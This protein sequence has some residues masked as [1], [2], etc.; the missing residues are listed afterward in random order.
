MTDTTSQVAMRPPRIEDGY[1]RP[2]VPERERFFG[3]ARSMAAPA[4][5]SARANLEASRGGVGPYFANMP[6]AALNLADAAVRGGVGAFAD[7]VPGLSPAAERDLAR[8]VLGMGEA[9]AGSVMRVPDALDEGLGGLSEVARRMF[10]EG[11]VPDTLYSGFDPQAYIRGLQGRAKESDAQRLREDLDA[12]DQLRAERG[13]PPLNPVPRPADPVPEDFGFYQDNPALKMSSG[14]EWLENKQRVADE[15]YGQRRGIT[16]STTATLGSG[17][18]DMFLPTDFMRRIPG[19]LDERRVPGEVQ[20]ERLMQDARERGFLP[21]QDGNR[22]VLGINHRGEAF[23]IEGNTR[24]A[25]AS[26][27]GIPNVRVEVRYKN[28]GEMVEGPFAPDN[29]ARI[30]ARGPSGSEPENFA[31]GGPVRGGI[32]SLSDMAR[33]MFRA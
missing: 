18:K 1:S 14:A 25:V 11:P 16:G 10:Q 2:T 17:D 32:G 4:L 12:N 19:L 26:D 22:I 29:I 7:L 9:A 6:M 23:I 31:Q 8:E 20:Y 5:E 28:G 21:D 3:T 30:A 33:G 27:L 15:T 24:T 13:L